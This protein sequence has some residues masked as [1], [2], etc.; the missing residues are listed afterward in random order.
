MK[1]IL[2]SLIFAS[3]VFSSSPTLPDH[4]WSLNDI[5]DQGISKIDLFK[6]MNRSLV[7]VND[8]IC[9]NRA[10]LWAHDFKRKN[11]LDTAKVFLFFT[12]RNGTFNGLT[13][14]YHVAPVINEDGVLWAMDAGFPKRVKGPLELKAWLKEFSREENCKE[15]R[16]GE[17]ELIERIFK[18]QT[19]PETT[20]YGSYGCY[21]ALAPQGYWTPGQLAMNLSG[22]D[23]SGSPVNFSRQEIVESDLWQ[24]CLEVSTTPIGWALGSGHKKCLNYLA[25]GF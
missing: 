9:S 10:H 11:G 14:W 23:G 12:R 22:H 3:S 7:R 4:D 21:Y 20:E 8:S 24:A 25:T 2:A 19:F 18:E 13:W 1:I 16:I 6:N 15:I 17:N 5:M